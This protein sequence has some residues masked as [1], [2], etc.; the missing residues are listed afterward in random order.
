MRRDEPEV[1]LWHIVFEVW[2]GVW[3]DIFRPIL[4]FA[5]VLFLAACVLLLPFIALGWIALPFVLAQ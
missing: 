2:V 3:Q 4:G 5:L 1:S